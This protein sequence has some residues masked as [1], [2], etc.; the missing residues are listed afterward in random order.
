[1]DLCLNFIQGKS[2]ATMKATVVQ[3]E[4]QQEGGLR[5]SGRH[6]EPAH[7]DS[8]RRHWNFT[9]PIFIFPMNLSDNDTRSDGTFQGTGLGATLVQEEKQRWV[10]Q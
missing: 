10:G 1:V 6:V 4:R 5:H 7:S 9:G 3:S 8:R 2:G